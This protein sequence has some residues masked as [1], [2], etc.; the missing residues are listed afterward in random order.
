[1]SSSKFSFLF[2]EAGSLIEPVS[3]RFSWLNGQQAPGTLFP[4]PPQPWHYR[5][6]LSQIASLYGYW[7][8]NSGPYLCTANALLTET[9]PQPFKQ[10]LLR[11]PLSLQL[12]E[13]HNSLTQM[14][15]DPRS[16]QMG[17]TPLNWFL[18]FS[19]YSSSNIEERT[20]ALELDRLGIA[21]YPVTS[22][23]VLTFHH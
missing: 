18:L 2:F 12:Q 20:W 19:P 8:S 3:H 17:Q 1:M 10:T 16:E 15:P 4:L 7:K 9:S 5:N 23:A 11:Y 21:S 13:P 14:S 22:L 6:V